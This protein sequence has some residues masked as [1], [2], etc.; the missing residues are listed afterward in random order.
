MARALPDTLVLTAQLIEQYLLNLAVLTGCLCFGEL[1]HIS[2]AATSTHSL[3]QNLASHFIGYGL[4]VIEKALSAEPDWFTVNIFTKSTA[5]LN[6]LV[7][8]HALFI[9]LVYRIE[10]FDSVL[11]ITDLHLFPVT[12]RA[13][14]HGIKHLSL[15][16]IDPSFCLSASFDKTVRIFDTRTKRCYGEFKGHKSIVSCAKFSSKDALMV[17]S[18]F[19]HSIRVWDT[20]A[21]VCV[22]TF[23]H[24]D[25]VCSFD[26]SNDDSTIAS[27]GMDRTVR[28][29]NISKGTC[30]KLFRG[31]DNWVKVVR[32]APNNNFVLSAGLDQ[33]IFLWDVNGDPS[34][35]VRILDAHEDYVLDMDVASPNHLV[36]VSRDCTVKKWLIDTGK[37]EYSIQVQQNWPSCVRF[38]RDGRFIATGSHDNTVRVYESK[39][40]KLIRQLKVQNDG[41]QS[42]CFLSNDSLLCGTLGGDIQVL[43]LWLV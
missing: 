7:S 8:S 4:P 21:A 23:L 9:Q 18:S 27:G 12:M 17:S 24:D 40:G 25:S 31:H 6:K 41:I 10:I 30:T 38:S 29:W 22:R 39:T 1:L 14:S 33:R 36:T 5:G 16:H 26:I 28:L 32:F 34:H 42:I 35:P 43:P 15:S 13:H 20:T 37:L 2:G 11:R 19:D 3:I